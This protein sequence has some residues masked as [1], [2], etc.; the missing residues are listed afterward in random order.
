MGKKM[1]PPVTSDGTGDSGGF[2]VGRAAVFLCSSAI[3]VG[4]QFID[5]AAARVFGFPVGDLDNCFFR[6]A[7][8]FGNFGPILR[9]CLS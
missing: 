8:T 4:E 5:R 2:L 6:N 7:G 3:K 1:P 9:H